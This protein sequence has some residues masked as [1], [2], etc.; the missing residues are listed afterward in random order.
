MTIRKKISLI[1]FGLVL[2]TGILAIYIVNNSLTTQN[3]ID[4][5]N[6][7]QLKEVEAVSEVTYTIQK[8]KTELQGLLLIHL[9]AYI[10]NGT[11]EVR[12]VHSA[13]K[14][15]ASSLKDLSNNFADLEQTTILGIQNGLDWHNQLKKIIHIKS[16]ITLLPE[17]QITLAA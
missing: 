1:L 15:I 4:R 11:E 8:I 12:K 16:N 2:L 7:F 5:I 6:L 17:K 3:H 9:S 10:N 14:T 13:K